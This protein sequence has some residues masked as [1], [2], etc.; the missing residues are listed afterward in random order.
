MTFQGVPKMHLQPKF[1][2]HT[3]R[4]IDLLQKVNYLSM[5]GDIM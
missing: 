2:N 1:C 3:S 4:K 5:H